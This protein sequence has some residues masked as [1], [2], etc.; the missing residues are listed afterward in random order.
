ML[1]DTHCHLDFPDFDAD[2]DQV[3]MGSKSG[4]ID[5]MINTASSV[6]SSVDS[7]LL[8]AKYDFIYATCGIHPHEADSVADQDLK[9]I[10]E[11]SSGKKTVAIGE[12]GLDYYLPAGRQGRNFS[13]QQNQKRLFKSLL[14][15]AKETALPVVIHTREAGADTLKIVDEFM[16]LQ[17]AIHCFSG[18]EEFLRQCLERGFYVSFTANITY[19]KAQGLRDMAKLTPLDRLMLE[20]DCPYLSPEGL[21]GRRNSPLAVKAVAEQV[22]LSKG[23][24]AEKI[25]EATSENA[26]KFFKLK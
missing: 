10:K 12:I 22:A 6:K 13:D 15:L 4:G 9:K 14:G 8:S 3:I 24:S 25:A 26:F 18:D 23:L 16:P 11:L 21:R 5:Y 1:I 17:A 20:T 7:S 2:R 19:K